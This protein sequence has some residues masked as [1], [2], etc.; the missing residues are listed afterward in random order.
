MPSKCWSWTIMMASV[1]QSTRGSLSTTHRFECFTNPG[2]VQTLRATGEFATL[3]DGCVRSRTPIACLSLIGLSEECTTF[4][5]AQRLSAERC[6]CV[7]GTPLRRL[8]PNASIERTISTSTANVSFDG[9]AVTANLF[10]MRT[11]FD[12]VGLFDEYVYANGD[13]EWCLRA[14]RSGYRVV[15]APDAIVFHPARDTLAK[16]LKKATRL[17]A[18]YKEHSGRPFWK[19]LLRH[20]YTVACSLRRRTYSAMGIFET[21]LLLM[22]LLGYLHIQSCKKPDRKRVDSAA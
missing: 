9:F 4:S 22:L 17:E 21:L 7:T 16:I 5:K 12:D 11:L 6:R 18:G 3:E 2:A 10:V 8:W 15:Y 19:G 14:A 13:R 20:L 1:P